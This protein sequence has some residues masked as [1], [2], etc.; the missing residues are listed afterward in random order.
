M[1]SGAQRVQMLDDAV[2]QPRIDAGERF[3]EQHDLRLQHQGARDLDQLALPVGKL[4]CPAVGDPGDFQEIEQ[5][6]RQRDRGAVVA[7]PRDGDEVFKHR[8]FRKQPAD[9]EGA[10]DAVAADLA[11]GCPRDVSCR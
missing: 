3:V 10:R 5:F 7:A 11:G 4:G 6:H 1:P 9:L 2:L 8:H